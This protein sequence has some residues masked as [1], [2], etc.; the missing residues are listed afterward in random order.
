MAERAYIL[1][2]R[3]NF[4]LSLRCH[5]FMDATVMRYEPVGRGKGRGETFCGGKGNRKGL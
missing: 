1:P 2:S 4:F 3:R 5:V